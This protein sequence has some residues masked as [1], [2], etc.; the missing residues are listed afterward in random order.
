MFTLWETRESTIGQ[1]GIHSN[2]GTAAGG[3][4]ADS[5][6]GGSIRVTDEVAKTRYSDF[7]I[8]LCKLM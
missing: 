6:R 1:L 5:P 7:S 3:G 4:K 8:R 2:G